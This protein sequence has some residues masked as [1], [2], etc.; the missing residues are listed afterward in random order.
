[1]LAKDHGYEA[2]DE[3]ECS[4]GSAIDES[5]ASMVDKIAK[6]YGVKSDKSRRSPF[7][8]PSSA[9]H[10]S[11]Q[12]F[13]FMQQ[14]FYGTSMHQQQPQMFPQ[15]PI[16]PSIPSFPP[17]YRGSSFSGRGR[18]QGVG[19]W[20]SI[21]KDCKGLGKRSRVPLVKS[22][23]SRVQESVAVAPAKSTRVKLGK[24]FQIK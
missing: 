11:A 5:T 7:K 12:N 19:K 10:L 4:G 21:C 16:M 15:M 14:P 18:A 24:A 17:Q 8:K 20:F 6:K 13:Q 1:M 22:C 2:A 23:R 9:G 3:F